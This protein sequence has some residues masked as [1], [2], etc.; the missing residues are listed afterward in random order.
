MLFSYKAI[1]SQVT[2]NSNILG[3]FDEDIQP[4]S[5]KAASRTA[6]ATLKLLFL[7][8]FYG[9]LIIIHTYMN[10]SRVHPVRG[11]RTNHSKEITY[12]TL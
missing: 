11:V 8:Y 3:C 7:E 4:S 10:I 2:L 12:C 5:S 6:K 1:I 9:K